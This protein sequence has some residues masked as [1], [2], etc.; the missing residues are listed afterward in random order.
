M[1]RSSRAKSRL[2]RHQAKVFVRQGVFYIGLVLVA[3]VL[4]LK[5]GIPL[6]ISLAVF[7][8]D[9]KSS[10]EK[11]EQVD[12]IPPI[13]PRFIPLPIATFSG[14]I[15]IAGF[16]EAGST[17]KAYINSKPA[18]EVITG[19]DGTFEIE[20]VSLDEGK[21]GVWASA[22]DSAGNKSHDSEVS[23]VERDD[24]SPELII[25]A[26]EDGIT[27]KDQSLEI[28]G[29]VSESEAEV[30]VN[31][32]FVVLSGTGA[33]TT[34]LT[35]SEGENKIIIKARDRAGNETEEELTVKRE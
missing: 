19:S 23:Y 21:N 20:K 24:K 22:V 28:K 15:K 9:L 3:M 34:K 11:V 17:V 1:I 7:L 2:A 13:A 27:T 29:K 6:L 10:S 12:N 33:F 16:A 32:R 30:T 35:L 25:D 31:G 26:P 14:Q 4:I 18:G 8:G 5:W